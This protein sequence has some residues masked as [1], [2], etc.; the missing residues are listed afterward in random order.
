MTF[1]APEAFHFV[2][3]QACDPD[4][5]ELLLYGVEGEG[6]YNRFDLFHLFSR[7]RFPLNV[8]PPGPPD[9]PCESYALP[10]RHAETILHSQFAFGSC[11][12]SS[13]IAASIAF[14]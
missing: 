11:V 7:S 13:A 9:E 3:C 10:N 14:S 5:L 2:D 8:I 4:A 1:L 6:F 12:D